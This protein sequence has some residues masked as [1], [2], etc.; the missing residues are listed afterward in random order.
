MTFEQTTPDE[1]YCY[2]L[3]SMEGRWE[4]G[5]CQM[6]YGIRIRLGVAGNGWCNLDYCAGDSPLHQQMLLHCVRTIL[7]RVPESI[8]ERDLED[9]FPRQNMKPI[10]NDPECFDALIAMAISA[11]ELND[12]DAQIAA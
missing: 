6:L 2:K 7:S 4:L 12:F 11:K 5:Y 8:R 9:M 10:N 3:A 1:N